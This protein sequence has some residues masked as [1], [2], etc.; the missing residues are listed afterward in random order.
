[1]TFLASHQRPLSGN[2]VNKINKLEFICR[3]KM[4]PNNNNS[5]F[6]L[7]ENDQNYSIDDVWKIASPFEY[8]FNKKELI[9]LCADNDIFSISIYLK[10]LKSRTPIML[11]TNDI[12]PKELLKILK[13]FRPSVLIVNQTLGIDAPYRFKENFENYII[14]SRLKDQPSSMPINKNLAVLLPT[15][16]STGAAKFVRISYKNLQ[17]NS[18]SIIKYLK[19]K[20]N[21]MTLT[22]L[23]MSYSFGLSI[24]NSYFYSGATLI[25]TNKSVVSRDFWAILKSNKITSISGVPYIF[26]LLDKLGFFKKNYPNLKTITQAGGRMKSDLKKTI[27]HYSI[28]NNIDFFVMYGQ[29]EAT[30][31]ISYVPPSILENKIDSIGIP[32]PDTKLNI[33]SKDSKE[34]ELIVEGKNVSLGYAI[35]YRD[36]S[37]GDENCGRL[38]TG[39]IGYKDSDGYFYITGRKSR[40]IKINSI[41]LSLDDAEKLIENE[42]QDLD[43]LCLGHDDNLVIEYVAQKN[44][45]EE[46]KS[47]ICKKIKIHHK[48][49]KISKIDKI[50][51]SSSGKKMYT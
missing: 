31:R 1:M 18:D 13:N 5:S 41:R 35:D 19:I 33:E 38:K 44:Y 6:K 24:L 22:T 8:I 50:V 34:G 45:D 40:F 37:K 2:E 43:A 51:R 32:I 3:K 17:S 36:L 27:L 28:L 20:S 7:I 9:I 10:A 23:P 15:S 4:I 48:H 39:D 26:E 47:F 25:I 42:F 29:T 30:A 12:D 16:G 49:L 14:F 46:I 21:D 11:L